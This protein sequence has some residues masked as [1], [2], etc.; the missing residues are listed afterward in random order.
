MGSFT[1]FGE[2]GGEEFLEIGIVEE[3]FGVCPESSVVGETELNVV[4][5]GG[6]EEFCY[7]GSLV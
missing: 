3:D 4:R 7:D 2:V 1:A 5:V 6:V